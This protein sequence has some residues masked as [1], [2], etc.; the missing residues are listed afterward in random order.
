MLFDRINIQAQYDIVLWSNSLL[1][2]EI[3]WL[4]H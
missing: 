3:S 4:Y 2:V 1:D